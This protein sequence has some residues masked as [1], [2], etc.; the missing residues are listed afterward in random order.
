MRIPLIKID[1]PIGTF[2]ISALNAEII[3]RITTVERREYGKNNL[4]NEGVQRAISVKRV[5]EIA[6]YTNDPDATFPTPIIIAVND[7]ATNVLGKDYFDFDEESIIGEI[8]DG[9][10]RVEGLKKSQKISEFTLP[11]ILMFDLLEEDKAYVFSIINSKQTQVTK[12]LIYDLFSLSE[13]RSPQ[14]TCHELARLLNS[15]EESPFYRRLK[16]LGAKANPD[17]SLSQGSFIRYLMPLI[18]KKPDED[19]VDIKLKKKLIDDP[20]IPLRF[21]FINNED[22]IIYKVLLNAF[23]ALRDTFPKEWATPDTYILSKTTG[24]GAV[25]GALK[26][27]VKEGRDNKDLTYD[28]FKNIFTNFKKDLLSKGQ[29]LTSQYY[30]SNE[31]EQSRLTKEILERK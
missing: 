19:Y 31:Q 20:T 13:N 29:E 15:D 16:M 30:K 12:S 26:V 14:K 25:I 18:S 28:Y 21:Y 7:T 23:K 27:L 6:K 3:C 4:P 24:Y 11:I 1:Q 22:Q 10:H 17:A 2:Y 8:I 5:N 9:Q